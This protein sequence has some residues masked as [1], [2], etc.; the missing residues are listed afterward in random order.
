MTNNKKGKFSDRINHRLHL[1]GL[2]NG[3]MEAAY[4]KYSNDPKAR[5]YLKDLDVFAA[6]MSKA[7]SETIE[8]TY[9]AFSNTS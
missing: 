9:N 2:I 3:C 7:L 1:L 6:S 5:N 4:E 8:T